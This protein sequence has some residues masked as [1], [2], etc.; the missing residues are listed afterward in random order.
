VFTLTRLL[1][2]QHYRLS[3]LTMT[4]TQQSAA[5]VLNIMFITG[6]RQSL[7]AQVIPKKISP[8]P[9][10]SYIQCRAPLN[11]SHTCSSMACDLLTPPM[12]LHS[13]H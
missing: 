12:Q 1:L 7:S 2:Q 3:I 6:K 8:L 9:G 5:A 10:T 4:G 13:L 11:S